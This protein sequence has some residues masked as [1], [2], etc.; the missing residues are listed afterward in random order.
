MGLEEA[1]ELFFEGLV[2]VF[3]LEDGLDGAGG[4]LAFVFKGLFVAANFEAIDGGAMNFEVEAEGGGMAIIL[5]MV[6]E[7]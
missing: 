4:F 6:L 5:A 3:G 2:W 1:V 7:E